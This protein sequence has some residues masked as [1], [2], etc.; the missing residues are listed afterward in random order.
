MVDTVDTLERPAQPG[1]TPFSWRIRVYWEDTDAGGV[2]YHAGY[3]C[4]MER[5]RSEWLRALG[6]DQ[7]RLREE[8]GLGFVVR[9]MQIDFLAPARLDDELDVT[10]E[11]LQ[12]RAVSLVFVQRVTR[13]ADGRELIRAQVRA[14]CVDIAGMRP[15]PIPDA[16]K[17]RI[18]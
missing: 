1:A 11:I 17:A 6:V 2:V 3:L 9:G 4:F 18:C 8:T 14:A 12:R 5:A 7:T 10:V 16:I 15:V 13:V